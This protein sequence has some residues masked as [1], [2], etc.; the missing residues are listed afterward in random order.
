MRKDW[1]KNNLVPKYQERLNVS[2]FL[3]LVQCDNRRGL[4][5]DFQ[6]PR[7]HIMPLIMPPAYHATWY[8][9]YLLYDWHC[10]LEDS[11]FVLEHSSFSQVSVL[12]WHALEGSVHAPRVTPSSVLFTAETKPRA[13]QAPRGWRENLKKK[14]LDQD[15][16][17]LLS[18][19]DLWVDSCV[20]END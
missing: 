12:F 7:Y 1:K 14:C 13:V 2:N 3:S 17:A 6:V 20:C 5:K 8:A 15:H 16:Q 18:L 11:S 10:R 9:I 19:P 4:A